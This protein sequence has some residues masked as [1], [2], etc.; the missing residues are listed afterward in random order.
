LGRD[1]IAAALSAHVKETNADEMV[2]LEVDGV[3]RAPADVEA[4]VYFTCLEA[5]QNARKHA[6][7]SAVSVTLRQRDSCI[8]FRVDDDG[9]GLG[10][11]R[12]TDGT[13]LRN[14]IDRIETVGGEL[15]IRSRRNR[16]TVIAGRVPLPGAAS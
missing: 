16:G 3:V 13:G 10:Q 15:D 7:A 8:E 9:V 1:G 5:L 12:A 11:R 14:M 2:S 4:A 6:G